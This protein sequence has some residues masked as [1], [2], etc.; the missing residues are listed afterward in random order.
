MSNLIDPRP[1]HESF[2]QWE[3]I[4]ETAQR[5]TDDYVTSELAALALSQ[6]KK[7]HL[8]VN[9]V[10]G[11]IDTSMKGVLE[12]ETVA[13]DPAAANR[14]I[15][16]SYQ[17]KAVVDMSLRYPRQ[18][19][20]ENGNR[21]ERSAADIELECDEIAV[22]VEIGGSRL[23]PE[24][25]VLLKKLLSEPEKPFSKSEFIEAG[26]DDKQEGSIFTGCIN[27]LIS[28]VN[29]SRSRYRIIKVGAPSRTRGY[30]LTSLL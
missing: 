23:N 3:L 30:K 21:S 2:E 18:V 20:E 14:L 10:L 6:F 27:M 22:A 19:E 28:K 8:L 1:I 5:S 4:A 25:R 13:F 24:E 12:D 9:E 26:F 7:S 16:L 29:D 17:R 15:G 11:Q